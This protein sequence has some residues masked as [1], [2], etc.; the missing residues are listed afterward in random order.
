MTSQVEHTDVGAY[1][2]GLLEDGDHRAFEAHLR[3]CAQC[4][5][6]LAEM[7]GTADALSELGPATDT[8]ED[9]PPPAV[10][11]LIQQQ[12]QRDRRARR[13]TYVI[14]AVAAVTVL[15]VG[16]TIGASLKD[17]STPP[18]AGGHNHGPAQSLVIWGDRHSG[19]DPATGVNG[20]VGLES[21]GWGTH[22]GLE[23]R[24][25]RGPLRCRLE[26]VSRSGERS[27]VTSWQVPAKGYGVPGSDAP[28]VTH[29]GTAIAAKDLARFEV[30]VEGG[31][32]TL[33]TIPM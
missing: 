14:G 7:A 3:D 8:A 6:E 26:A 28:L 24:G 10:I 20:V 29:G 25:V 13:G 23:L 5:A 2:L 30:R 16:I 27:V 33:L 19:K 4:Q 12:Q 22:V 1:A 31:D 15:A 17:D 11:D 32:Q 9:A 18:V 21:K